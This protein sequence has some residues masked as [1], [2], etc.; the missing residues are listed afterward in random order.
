[1][2]LFMGHKRVIKQL[3]NRNKFVFDRDT[4]IYETAKKLKKMGLLNI[5]Y[6]SYLKCKGSNEVKGVNVLLVDII[7]CDERIYLNDDGKDYVACPECYTENE[8]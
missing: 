2:W 4:D 6:R 5:E 3:F 8:V 1:M 7:E